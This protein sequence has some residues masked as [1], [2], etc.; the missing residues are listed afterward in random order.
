MSASA[1]HHH[2][3]S[4]ASPGSSHSSQID[5]SSFGSFA[6]KKLRRVLDSNQ[7]PPPLPDSS[8]NKSGRRYSKSELLDIWASLKKN[9]LLVKSKPS[10]ENHASALDGAD[11]DLSGKQTSDSA[12]LEMIFSATI[13]TPLLYNSDLDKSESSILVNQMFPTSQPGTSNHFGILGLEDFASTTAASSPIGSASQLHPQSSLGSSSNSQNSQRAFGDATIGIP[14]LSSI[15][16]HLPDYDTPFSTNPSSTWSPFSGTPTSQHAQLSQPMK[17]PDPF[18]PSLFSGDQQSSFV[19]LPRL[20]SPPSG[21][22][23]IQPLPASTPGTGSVAPPGLSLPMI[24]SSP[25]IGW[26]YLDN[27]GL[28]QGP[29]PPNLM[30]EWYE[31]EWLKSDLKLR[32][33]DEPEFYTLGEFVNMVGNDLNPFLIPFPRIGV[34]LPLLPLVQ[35]SVPVPVTTPANGLDSA[36]IHGSEKLILEV[37]AEAKPLPEQEMSAY[38]P[39]IAIKQKQ[40]SPVQESVLPQS[41]ISIPTKP[42]E[43]T[44]QQVTK[45]TSPVEPVNEWDD[46]P[47]DEQQ[48]VD[49]DAWATGS[50][51][52]IAA[53]MAAAKSTAVKA[54]PNLTGKHRLQPLPPPPML[55]M[56]LGDSNNSNGPATPPATLTSV[57]AP[58][59]KSAATGKK[60]KPVSVKEIEEREASARKQEQSKRWQQSLSGQRSVS[61]NSP[62]SQVSAAGIANIPTVPAPGL[63]S[64]ATWAKNAGNVVSASGAR[65]SLAQIQKEEQEASRAKSTPTTSSTLGRYADVTASRPT[66]LAAT[67]AGKSTTVVTGGAWTTVGSGGKKTLPA[68]TIKAPVRRVVSTPTPVVIR[69]GTATAPAKIP[70]SAE[71]FF[72][73]CRTTLRGVSAGVNAEDLLSML[74]SLP[75]NANSET[76]EIIADSI[77][78]NSTTMDGRRFAEE[79]VKRRRSVESS[80]I[81]NLASLLATSAASLKDTP[82]LPTIPVISRTASGT[83][84]MEGWNEVS[85]RNSRP[86]K[87]NDNDGWNSAF[88]VIGKKKPSKH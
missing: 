16:F 42:D 6:E 2:A 32:R 52:S 38:E 58:W 12:D 62:I 14:N 41:D 45:P 80:G 51:E 63:P 70:T 30:H 33:V 22:Q 69:S 64:T 86:T 79:F 11:I 56:K 73:W 19:P 23:D 60:S 3:V 1:R 78:A 66:G 9:G 53:V 31:N 75:S 72:K 46:V 43:P 40:I 13:N 21:S 84:T 10:F 68:T 57:P 81:S 76:T 88:K 7:S 50:A 35:S 47:V 20:H 37:A 65:K 55:H 67:L 5:D 54:G 26:L 44:N 59:A 24:A 34:D 85:A 82:P 87:P 36:P 18:L 83:A 15:P 28:T 29:F 25:N 61:F 49:D 8:F 4:S 48:A 39:S 27:Q 17:S 77:Y 71:D 74:L